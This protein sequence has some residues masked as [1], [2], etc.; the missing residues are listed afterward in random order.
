MA[1]LI[2]A[3]IAPA[4]VSI[5]G[6]WAMGDANAPAIECIIFPANTMETGHLGSVR[7]LG[8]ALPMPCRAARCHGIEWHLWWK[9]G[10][11]FV[12]GPGKLNFAVRL[13]NIV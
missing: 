2:R 3:I 1:G 6:L 9:Y 13:S 8:P 7:D 4:Y 11:T 10:R 5:Y 12:C